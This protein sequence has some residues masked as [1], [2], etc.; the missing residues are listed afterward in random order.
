VLIQVLDAAG[1]PHTVGFQGQDQINDYSGSL[2]AG[3]VTNPQ[4]P[5]P[6]LAANPNRAGLLFQNTSANPMLVNEVN[7]VTA[8]SWVVPPGGYFPPYPG[9]AIPAGILYV[10]GF[11]GISQVGDT[12]A[13]R[14]FTN[15][16]GE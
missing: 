13:L 16:V 7:A 5:Q 10:M 14:E 9:L 11:P 12:F 8:S 1:V 2:G 6:V 3:A 15:A 4:V